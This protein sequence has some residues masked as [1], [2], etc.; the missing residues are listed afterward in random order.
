MAAYVIMVVKVSSISSTDVQKKYFPITGDSPAASR[1]ACD[2]AGQLLT[3]LAS[4]VVKGVVTA[5]VVDAT[6]TLSTGSIACTRAN[7]AGNYVRFTW[8]AQTITLTEGTD[9]LRGASDT[10][11]GAALEAAINAHATLKHIMTAAAVTG[12]VTCTAKFPSALA[13]SVT[14]STDDATAFGLT[15]FASGTTGAAK[16]FLQAF[17]TGV[18]P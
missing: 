16:F 2:G 8:G 17:P 12:T 14:M 9:F 11:C 18:T 5:S 7:A 13:H 1:R 4:G 15:A 3:A 10:T 6:G